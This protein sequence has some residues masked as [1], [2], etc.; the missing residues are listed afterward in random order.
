MQEDAAARLSELIGGAIV[1][2]SS[3]SYDTAELEKRL[4]DLANWLQVRCESYPFC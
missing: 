2:T 3:Y 1:N 4:E